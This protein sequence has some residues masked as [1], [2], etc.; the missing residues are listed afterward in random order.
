MPGQAQRFLAHTN[1]NFRWPISMP[2]YIRR[3]TFMHITDDSYKEF[4]LEVGF[5]YLFFYNALDNNEFAEHK[6]EWVTVHKQRV[7]EYGQRYDDDRLNDILEAM[8]G[9]VQLPVDQTKLLRS[10]PAKIVTVQHVNNSN[11]YKV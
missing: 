8:P 7:V 5:N 2:E 10:P 11:D 9:A 1:K 4:G 6:N 3:G